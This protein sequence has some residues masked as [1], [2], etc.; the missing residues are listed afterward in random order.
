M[1]NKAKRNT[2]NIRLID[3]VSS[4]IITAVEM[5]CVTAPTKN[6]VYHMILFGSVTGLGYP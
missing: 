2:G 6:T 4:K 3:P 1:K 5:V